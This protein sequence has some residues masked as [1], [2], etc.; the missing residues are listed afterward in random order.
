MAGC[1]SLRS[2]QV[3]LTRT[4]DLAEV[5]RIN[6]ALDKYESFNRRASKDLLYYLEKGELLRLA[7]RYQES[8]EAWARADAQVQKWENAAVAN[9]QRLLGQA[10]A[11]LVNDATRPYEGKDF[12][13]VMITTRMALN[14]LALGEWDKARVA[15]KRSHEREA[16]IAQIRE[17]QVQQA[18]EEA[19]KKG[20]KRGFRELDGYPVQTIDSPQVNALR[21]SY[22]SAF[23]H[24]LAGF[25]YEALG[26]PSL[27][28]AGYRQAIELQPGLPLLDQG[29]A[30]LDSRV[31]D[32]DSDRTELLVV[33]ESGVAPARASEQ[34]NLPVFSDA[35]L[36]VV[37]MSFPVI[38]QDAFVARVQTVSLDEIGTANVAS[39]TSIDLMA[40]RALRDEMP[41]I[42]LRAITRATAKAII[43][44]EARR[45]DDS[46]VA[47]AVAIIGS[48][49]TE[50]ADERCWRM[51]PAQIAVARAS[52]PP[53]RHKLAVDSGGSRHEF[54]VNVAG[55][56]ALV[57][58]RMLGAEAYIA[59]TPPDP[60]QKARNDMQRIGLR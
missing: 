22:Q 18:Q 39:I 20:E 15:I 23:S 40:R 35:G 51:L 7:G 12:E 41:W 53:G 57:S 4:I 30:G 36:L 50:K 27:A 49:L 54:D 14:H 55:R 25:V 46:G 60:E 59:A 34:F 17:K 19:E 48:V 26:E 2:Y 13:K 56:Y 52:V 43:Q 47:A 6:T 31:A 8:Q 10:A 3:E 16:L 37:P 1:G 42:M 9:P 45:R 58:I 44:H 28:A 32:R 29:L 11:L 5:G 21:N 33:M 24:Y 38:R